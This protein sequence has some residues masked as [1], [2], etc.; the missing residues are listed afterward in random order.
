MSKRT[1]LEYLI[2]LP[3]SEIEHRTAATVD[4][5][6]TRS[7]RALAESRDLTDREA[8]LTKADTE[9]LTALRQA[10]ACHEVIEARG[11]VIG[12][13]ISAATAPAETRS[14]L[15]SDQHLR[16]HAAALSEGRPYGAVETRARVT[17]AGDLGSAGAWHPGAPDEPRH[18]IAFAGIP[19][20]ELTGRTAQV[21]A[22]TGPTAAAGA[23]EST[24]HGEYDSVAPVNLTALR[25]GRWSGVSALANVVD[26]LLGLNQMH[27]WGIA[28]DLDAL[29]VQAV[30]DAAASLGAS[31]DV[32]EAVRRA[33]LTV[34]ANTYSDE[35]QLVVFGDPT[36][37]AELTGTTPAN[38]ADL[39]SHA[40]RFAGAKV[41]PTTAATANVL[42]VF[43]PSG[44]RV[45]QSPLQSASL[46]DPADGS[47][48][49]GSWIHST[50]IAEQI[51]GSAVM[52]GAS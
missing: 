39:G 22:Y 37:L 26:D 47:H 16:E 18:L 2:D 50:G 21:P 10:A 1:E 41:Y 9:E 17:A 13:A 19:V 45:F 33:I 8:V 28:R 31:V 20:S 12:E 35:T 6:E 44:F 11:R 4:R 51:V 36:A 42:T 48:K 7:Q 40:V 34:A 23:D 49:F 43:A 14:L 27:A 5:I 52:V 32:E 25:Y 46:I 29:A 30:E 24:D 38:A 15:V 3:A